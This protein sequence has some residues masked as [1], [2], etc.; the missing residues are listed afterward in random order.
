MIFV[1]VPILSL[2]SWNVVRCSKQ[3]LIFYKFKKFRIYRLWSFRLINFVNDPKSDCTS[4]WSVSLKEMDISN[5]ELARLEALAADCSDD[6]DEK[7][8]S[9]SSSEDEEEVTTETVTGQGYT[10]SASPMTL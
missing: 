5:E 4:S 9:S 2:V 1:I 3:M 8:S 7:S 10:L 6:S